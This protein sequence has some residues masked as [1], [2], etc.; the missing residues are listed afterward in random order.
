MSCSQRSRIQDRS[1]GTQGVWFGSD[2]RPALGWLSRPERSLAHSG[3]V[4][5]PPFGYPY[6]GSH[7][8][9]R[10]LA[11]RLAARGHAVLR[12]DYDGTGDS[13]GDQWDPDRVRAWRET[14]RLG[15][16]ELRRLG[17]QQITLVGVRIGGTIALLDGRSLDADRVVAWMPVDAGRRYAKEL[18]LL[19]YPVPEDADPLDPPGTRVFAGSVFSAQTMRDLRRLAVTDITEPPARATLVID[20]PRGSSINTVEHLRSVGADVDHVRLPG[21]EHSLEVA[22]EYAT[23]PQQ[24]VAAACDWI[25][26]VGESSDEASPQSR[27]T[28]TRLDWRGRE[29]E[30]KV[31]TLEPHGH[32][33]LI[34]SP[35]EF[36]PDASTLVLL[37]PGSETHVGP[38][39][40]WVEYARELALAGRRTI[41]VD[42][43]GWGE[44]PDAGRAPGRPYDAACEEDAVAIVAGLRSAGYRRLVPFGLCASAW[45]AL[46]AVLRSPVAGVIAMNPQ[47]YWEPGDL[48]EIDWDMI[49]ADRA[50]EIRQVALGA[51]V[52]VWSLLDA[53]GRRP[54]AARWLEDLAVTGIPVHLLFTEADDGLVYLE[55]RLRRRMDR[56]RRKSNVTLTVLPEVDHPMHLTWL[57]PRVVRALREALDAI[58][59]CA[60]GSGEGRRR[61]QAT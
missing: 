24:I 21:S 15:V 48:V 30:E 13:A 56:L 5:A 58:D 35:P 61:V 23:V 4:T 12:I 3:V 42:F 1:T 33:A 2:E 25:G 60:G 53:I 37:N 9:L 47:L 10:V 22:P 49:R 17:A 18:R 40:A 31:V 54:R 46:R 11:E 57:R 32:V 7:R 51:R 16:Q 59:R 28:G 41:R 8:S 43:L 27:R 55:Q 29:I 20:D 34:T 6:W 26:D 19:S 50:D 38:G 44:S 52:G 45:I 14:L 39:R 36:D